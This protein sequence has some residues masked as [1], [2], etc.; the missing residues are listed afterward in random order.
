MG[1]VAG[2]SLPGLPVSGERTE[3]GRAK[4]NLARSADREARRR[5]RAGQAGVGTLADLAV[6]VTREQRAHPNCD[7]D[8]MIVIDLPGGSSWSVESVTYQ[9]DLAGALVIKAGRQLPGWIEPGL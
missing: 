2:P 3:A 5:S 7:R 8:T 1:R 4:R 6:A 9:E